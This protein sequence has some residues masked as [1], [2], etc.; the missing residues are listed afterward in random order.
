MTLELDLQDITGGQL[1]SARASLGWSSEALAEKA[2]VS[3]RTIMRAEQTDGVIHARRATII[4]LKQ[5]LEAAG[6]EFIGTPDDGPGIRL[7][8]PRS[9]GP[10][11]S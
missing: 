1:R 10:S 6:I 11:S 2:G 5:T 7:R 3:Q 4:V 8:R 9:L